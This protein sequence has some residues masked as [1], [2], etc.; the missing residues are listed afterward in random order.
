MLHCSEE[1]SISYQVSQLL[2][3]LLDLCA[4]CVAYPIDEPE[5][6]EAKTPV[7]EVSGRDGRKLPTLKGVDDNRA[8][9]SKR[10]GQLSHRSSTHRI[11]DEAK[12]LPAE[13]L[14][15]VLV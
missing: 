2:V 1:R 7:D 3:S 10:F 15:N 5:S 9:R 14:L 6:V 8:A 12:F 13:S 4:G 11:E